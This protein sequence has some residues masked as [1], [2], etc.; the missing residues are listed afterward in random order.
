MFTLSEMQNIERDWRQ[1][2]GIAFF[3]FLW[4]SNESLKSD[5]EKFQFVQFIRNNS[6]LC[7]TIR[8]DNTRKF[9]VIVTWRVETHAKYNSVRAIFF[10]VFLIFIK[11][12]FSKEVK[13]APSV[14]QI[15][16]MRK[17]IILIYFCYKS[18]DIKHCAIWYEF[19]YYKILLLY[20]RE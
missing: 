12:T 18:S 15:V 5:K 14:C 16:I 13:K 9:K 2:N 7:N 3:S 17:N 19:I 20:L 4:Y 10:I 11:I 8:Y 1:S 6:R